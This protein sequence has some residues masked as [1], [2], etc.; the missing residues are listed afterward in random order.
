MFVV[1]DSLLL[2]AAQQINN[3]CSWRRYTS[4]QISQQLLEQLDDLIT[5]INQYQQNF[6]IIRLTEAGNL[7]SPLYVQVIRG[8]T[9]V[10]VFEVLNENRPL[11]DIQMGCLGELLVLQMTRLGLSTVWLGGDKFCFSSSDIKKRVGT[12]NSIPICIPFIVRNTMC[13]EC[14]HK[15]YFNFRIIIN[16]NNSQLKILYFMYFNLFLNIYQIR[17][18]KQE[19]AAGQGFLQIE[20]INITRYYYHFII[21]LQYFKLK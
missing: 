3:R 6:K 18:V 20:E 11:V 14:I 15:N 2:D 12:Q 5:I 4:A 7:L 21:Y 8:A 17:N 9:N 13:L 19:I 1:P 10:I 16:I